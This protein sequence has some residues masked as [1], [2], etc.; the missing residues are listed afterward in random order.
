MAVRWVEMDQRGGEEGAGER[1]AV[2]MRQEV[3]SEER[4]R[5]GGGM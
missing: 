4:G 3:D 2:E 5:T 1:C